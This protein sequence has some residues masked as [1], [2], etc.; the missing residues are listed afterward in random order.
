M[1]T[2]SVLDI[3]GT[4]IKHAR[5]IDGKLD[6]CSL[7]STPA[8]A[9]EDASCVLDSIASCIGQTDLACLCM[10]GPM[11]YAT[12]KSLMK[13]KFPALYGIEIRTELEKCTQVPCVISHDVVSF[14]AGVMHL[15]E[16]A[17]SANPAAITLGTGLGYAHARQGVIQ[18]N[19]LGSPAHPL[20]NE[21]WQDGIAEGY[22]SARALENHFKR[23]T[24]ESCSAREIALRANEGNI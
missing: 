6:Q 20:W 7:Q 12:G 18:V 14:L 10:P 2:A 5:F 24:G 17:N 3:G 23:H 19:D 21:P 22:V 15:G 11:E 8:R 16:T 13:H 1:K 4:F 9:D